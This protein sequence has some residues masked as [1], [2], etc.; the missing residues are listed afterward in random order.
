MKEIKTRDK[1]KKRAAILE[2]AIDV[3]I[4]LGYDLASMDKIAENANVSKRT[5]YNHFANKETLFQVVVNDFLTERQKLK[6]IKYDSS[7]SLEE[8]LG[9]FIDAEIFLIDS[10]KRLGLSRFLTITFLKD[11][12][13]ARKTVSNYPPTSNMFIEWLKDSKED[14]KIKADNLFLAAQLFYALI[15][16]AITWPVLFTEGIDKTVMKPMYNEVIDTFLA[17]Y[18]S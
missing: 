15:V 16:G 9:A 1:G 7:K 14:G 13:Y 5:I 10:P 3:F 2:G 18:G 6:T 11:I 17:K 12:N 8:Q 4:E